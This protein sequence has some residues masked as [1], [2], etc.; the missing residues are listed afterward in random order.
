MTGTVDFYRLLG[1]PWPA[2]V[3]H[4]LNEA[5]RAARRGDFVAA[6]AFYTQAESAARKAA[7]STGFADRLGTTEEDVRTKL[8]TISLARAS[9][10]EEG[11]RAADAFKAYETSFNELSKS[12]SAA[13]KMRAVALAQKLGDLAAGGAVT[14]PS[15]SV[16]NQWQDMNALAEQYYSWAVSTMMP[17][18]LPPSIH[19]S[20]ITASSGGQGIGAEGPARAPVSTSDLKEAFTT[21]AK[22]QDPIQTAFTPLQQLDVPVWAQSAN[23][24]HGMESLASFYASRGRPERAAQIYNHAISLVMS[25]GST[26]TL[27]PTP[28]AL[29]PL[30]VG[31]QASN[32]PVDLATEAKCHAGVL[33]YK[34]TT[35][36]L[37]A[38]ERPWE[39]Q[40]ATPAEASA[41][42]EQ[43][44][45]RAWTAARE[46][47]ALI[48]STEANLSI[49]VAPDSVTAVGR[50]SL[51]PLPSFLPPPAPASSVT[52]E[53]QEECKLAEAGLLFALGRS[54]AAQSGSSD[55]TQGLYEAA[56]TAAQPI[57]ARTPLT[58]E[59][60]VSLN[61]PQ[62]PFS[63][64]T[65]EAAGELLADIALAQAS[66]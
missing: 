20:R 17:L 53:T 58:H 61:P 49:P 4:E 21:D 12:D 2:S 32:L 52:A 45:A 6:V 9:A 1:T 35:A 66:L 7:Q 22:L 25:P 59:H 37:A 40:G 24:S 64:T 41:R 42:Q 47:L 29:L 63:H 15:P 27:P 39:Q 34:L 48:R 28:A 54:V 30:A 13:D 38:S 11:G 8:A 55:K 10:L 33:Y 57:A 19:G 43:L 65:R 62:E 16:P 36:L 3:R 44:R 26:S 18:A 5:N 56:A 31:R 46:G 60:V 51:A 14:L 50:G 23:L